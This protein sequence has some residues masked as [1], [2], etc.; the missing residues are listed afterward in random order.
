MKGGCSIAVFKDGYQSPTPI[1]GRLSKNIF[2]VEANIVGHP[3]GYFI[4]VKLK[5]NDL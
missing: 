4:N 3:V 2:L 1:H 5:G